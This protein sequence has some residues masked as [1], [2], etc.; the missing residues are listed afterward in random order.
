MN[1]VKVA[2]DLG[3]KKA[4]VAVFLGDQLVKALTVRDTRGAVEMAQAIR[5]WADAPEGAIWVIE[6]PQEYRHR[7]VTHRDLKALQALRDVLEETVG[8]LVCYTPHQWKGHVP[9]R[10]MQQRLE[11]Q[12]LLPEGALSLGHD[13]LD[14]I[15]L[16][17]FHLGLT[18]KGGAKL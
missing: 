18:G 2:V 10:V 16:G 7:S 3:K 13:A 5:L 6:D 15:G 1:T 9:K 8:P 14:A 17:Y 12:G 4:G 11:D